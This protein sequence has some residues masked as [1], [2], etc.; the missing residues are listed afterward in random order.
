MFVFCIAG[1][2]CVCVC[3]CYGGHQNEGCAYPFEEC[4]QLW[5]F[6][7]EG[8]TPEFHFCRPDEVWSSCVEDRKADGFV[9]L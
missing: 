5:T 9:C 8:I 1:M 3:V 7:S 4:S 2:V 6:E